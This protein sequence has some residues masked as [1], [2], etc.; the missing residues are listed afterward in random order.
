MESVLGVL[1]CLSP[2]LLVS[3]GYYIGRYGS[4]IVIKLQPRRD[5]RLAE[6][7]D[8][9]PNETEHPENPIIYRF[10]HNQRE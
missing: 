10:N 2:L 3:F 9:T 7:E 5:R 6:L 1:I 4:P 8:D